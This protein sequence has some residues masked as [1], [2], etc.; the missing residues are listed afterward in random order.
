MSLAQEQL[1]L[2]HSSSGLPAVAVRLL[3]VAASAFEAEALAMTL[4]LES[5]ILVVGAASTLDAATNHAGRR[6][7]DAVLV[8]CHSTQLALTFVRALR[9]INPGEKMVV[10]NIPEEDAHVSLWA[11][12][13]PHGCIGVSGTTD[14]V[15][16]AVRSAADGTYSCSAGFASR[17]LKVAGRAGRGAADGGAELTS[18]EIDV[19][20]LLDQR[21][22]N[23]EIAAAL[24]IEVATVKNHVQRI[25]RKLGV[26]KR[27]DALLFVG[28]P[29]L[30]D[31]H[32]GTMQLDSP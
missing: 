12:I 2:R 23:R 3:L 18:R 31:E 7:H 26:H 19:L 29:E 11:R 8:A 21:L 16:T 6:T 10:C 22:S 1:P 15:V 9:V 4:E 13:R 20:S 17:L 5:A 24:S 30:L 25:F 32:E 28:H 14:E 27:S